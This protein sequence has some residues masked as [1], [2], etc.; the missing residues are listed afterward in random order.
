MR[1]DDSYV[2][3]ALRLAQT[4]GRK[5]K[6]RGISVCPKYDTFLPH[7]HILACAFKKVNKK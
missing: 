2:G 4:K 1:R 5:L 6:K 3:P 7:T